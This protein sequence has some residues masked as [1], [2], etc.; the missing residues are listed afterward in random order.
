M[1]NF[2]KSEREND[3][4]KNRHNSGL[5]GKNFEGVW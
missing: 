4:L 3:V 2:D 1:G 5:T